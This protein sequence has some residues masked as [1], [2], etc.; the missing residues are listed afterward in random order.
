MSHVLLDNHHDHPELQ[1]VVVI[2]LVA[3]ALR[4]EYKFQLAFFGPLL[5]LLIEVVVYVKTSTT[6]LNNH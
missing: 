5:L 4:D 3:Q 2:A 1:V 6:F